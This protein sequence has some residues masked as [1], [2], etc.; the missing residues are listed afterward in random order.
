MKRFFTNQLLF[1]MF[2]VG[3]SASAQVPLHNSYP[4]A[5][6][7][8]FL[9]FD[10]HR[11]DGTAWNY[12][13]PFDCGAS[14]LNAAQITEVF[15]RVAE[16]Y[17]PFDI[18]VTTDSA[19]YLA[20]PLNKRIRIILTVT[21]DWYGSAGGV[22]YFGS[23]TWGDNTPAFVFTA[24]LG[25][26]IKFISEAASHEAGHSLNLRHQANYDQ[27]CALVSQYHT[28][29][30]SGEIGWA[31]IM[32]VGYYRNQTVW[33]N[34]TDPY[35][36]NSIQ[37]DLAVITTTNGF[38]YRDDDNNG[39]FNGN[40]SR[41]EFVNNEFSYSGVVETGADVDVVR[42]T[43]PTGGRFQ[44]N[45]APSAAGAG[46]SGANLDLQ[47]EL[48]NSANAVVATYNPRQTLDAIV[49]TI[50]NPGNYFLRIKG[51]GNDFT[52]QYASIGAYTLTAKYTPGLLL[53][54]RRLELQGR[55]TGSTAL[56]SWVVD[57]DE[58]VRTQTL[59]SSAD[60]RTFQ[61]VYTPDALARNINLPSAGGTTLYRLKVLFANGQTHYSNTLT[62]RQNSGAAPYLLNNSVNH[63]VRV[64]TLETCT[65]S[66]YD[67]SG[68]RLSH[69]QLQKGT[70][71]IE[72][73]SLPLG[74]Y[75]LQ[76]SNS[77]GQYPLKFRKQ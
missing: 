67:Y 22:A 15:N 53:S 68:R 10:G 42:F 6:A 19:K 64:S 70:T 47:V 5:S 71:A 57:A 72:T 32:G 11:V 24:L 1:L 62:L 39:S 41:V 2:C 29:I 35:G 40:G 59:E 75:V 52:P 74:I 30:G 73:A 37:N 76:V 50:L 49:D 43:M 66:L 55:Q 21:S 36:C 48:L 56:L 65:Y 46:N 77:N 4:S 31:P 34:G 61:T 51:E 60:G 13:G 33:N 14:G 23:F 8:I 54:V 18:N 69:G 38:G 7:T 3:S 27:N 20:A 25:Y 45:A 44:L 26:S 12:S 28:G 16:D 17:R 63:T 9:D 58:P